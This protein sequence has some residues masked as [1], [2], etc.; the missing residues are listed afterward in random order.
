MSMIRTHNGAIRS[1]Q[2]QVTGVTFTANQPPSR[3][4]VVPSPVFA[5]VVARRPEAF[6]FRTLLLSGM[7]LCRMGALRT[8]AAFPVRVLFVALGVLISLL[9]IV[10]GTSWQ[11]EWDRM[12]F[13]GYLF[14][15]KN[16]NIAGF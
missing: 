5:G 3:I 8:Y 9:L 6:G 16:W 13:S 15:G 12:N 10:T 11:E 2:Q 7:G 14:G 1:F 4:R